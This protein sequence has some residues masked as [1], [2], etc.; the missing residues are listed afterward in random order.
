M[1]NLIIT[2]FLL[3]PF[4]SYSQLYGEEDIFKNKYKVD[5]TTYRKFRPSV[6]TCIYDTRL[7]E[8]HIDEK[9]TDSQAK[10]I[11]ATIGVE[12]AIAISKYYYS[13][14]LGRAF[15]VNEVVNSIAAAIGCKSI[16]I[17]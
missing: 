4:I 8:L 6:E 9:A 14:R 12:D 17:E 13:V 11:E 5:T 1:K 10:I 3:L 2:L 7:H 15:D 16:T